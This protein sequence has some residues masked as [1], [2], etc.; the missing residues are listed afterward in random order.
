MKS[1][2][3]GGGCFWCIDAVYRQIKGVTASISGYA[4]GHTENPDYQSV[5]TG[6]TGHYEVVKVEF[7]ETVID[8]YTVLDI[9]F[10]SH[11][12]TSWDRQGHDAG[13]QYRSALL[14]TNSDEKEVFERAKERAQSIWDEEIVTVI[15]PL[16]TFYEAEE[17]HQDY[18]AR[19]P[20][21]G[22]CQ[23]IINP[24]VSAARRNFA[25]YLK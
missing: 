8:E 25:Q 21:A 12:P 4:G 13:S 6:T 2:V 15:E 14:Y 20:F 5:C 11:N 9:F 7:D 22:Y 23:A 3:V 1:F 24:K 10:T 18:Y 19:N 17:Y 16:E